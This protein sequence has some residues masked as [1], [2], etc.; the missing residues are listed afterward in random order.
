MCARS[1][2]VLLVLAVSGCVST[3]HVVQYPQREADL[4]PLSQTQDGISVAIDEVTSAQRSERYFGADLTR[5]N[6][7][8]LAI[9]VS[10]NSGHRITVAP[11]DVLLYLG[12]RVI[13][14]LPLGE[15]VA[16]AQEEHAMESSQG[17]AEKYFDS[18][19]LKQTVLPPGASYTGVMFF[20]L[21]RPRKED[22][23]FTVLPLFTQSRL[24]LMIGAKD[25]YTRTRY[26]FG[27]FSLASLSDTGQ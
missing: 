18:L 13:D 8:P 5:R 17:D 20:S 4:Y 23:N 12:V 10:N 6:I 24:Q 7:L 3:Y 27:P 2:V 15:V 22:S 16:T 9:I 14:P 19:A 11:A 25:L 1:L 21:P 26:H